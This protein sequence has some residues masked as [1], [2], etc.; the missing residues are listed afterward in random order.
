MPGQSCA[1]VCCKSEGVLCAELL[2]PVALCLW[3]MSAVVL[4]GVLFLFGV[5]NWRRGK[6]GSSHDT[7]L[8]FKNLSAQALARTV[9]S[10][11]CPSG[12]VDILQ[13]WKYVCQATLRLP[14]VS[15]LKRTGD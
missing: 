10:T 6:A 4:V 5:G 2:N 1:S 8:G 7:G 15:T 12:P 14:P 13:T 9:L 11:L 3:K